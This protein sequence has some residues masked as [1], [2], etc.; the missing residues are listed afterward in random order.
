MKKCVLVP[1]IGKRDSTSL[2][3]E[4]RSVAGEKTECERCCNSKLCNT[5]TLSQ[6]AHITT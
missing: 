5:G 3:L 4:E 2:L 1:V 6:Y